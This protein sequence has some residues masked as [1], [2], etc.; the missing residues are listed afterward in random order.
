MF[1]GAIEYI[2]NN[3]L[4]LANK[5]LNNATDFLFV[6]DN[7]FFSETLLTKDPLLHKLIHN[8]LYRRLFLRALVI[9]RDNIEESSQ[10]NYKEFQDLSQ[11]KIYN[12]KILRGLAEKIWQSSGKPCLSEEIWID[13]PAFPPTKEVDE[14]FIKYPSE[15]KKMSKLFPSNEWVD[16]YA[17]H[18]WK[19]HVFCP[20]E[21]QKQVSIAAKDVLEQVFKFKLKDIAWKSCHVSH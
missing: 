18:K 3:G 15:L 19:A 12:Y 13:V 5:N 1:K 10:P 16:M 2:R 21:C 17:F 7:S 4:T 9:T 8:I 20:P 14:T 11:K 6:T